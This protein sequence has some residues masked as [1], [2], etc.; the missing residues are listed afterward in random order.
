M[1]K[2]TE[3]AYIAGFWE[4]EG[5]A[6]IYRR[7]KGRYRLNVSIVNTNKSVLIW[8][9]NK[10]GYGCICKKPGCKKS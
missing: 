1:I 10:L 5:S 8:I 7:G 6:G 3:I 4:G 9:K 2:K